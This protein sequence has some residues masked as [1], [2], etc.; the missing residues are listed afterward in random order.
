M[1][2]RKTRSW[3]MPDAGPCGHVSVARLMKRV[4]VHLPFS[5]LAAVLI[6]SSNAMAAFP[7]EQRYFGVTSNAVAVDKSDFIVRAVGDGTVAWLEKTVGGYELWYFD[8]EKNERLASADDDL[9]LLKAIPF[10]RCVA[11]RVRNFEGNA[12]Q[13]EI[14]DPDGPGMLNEPF[15]QDSDPVADGDR[16][17]WNRAIFA[18]E[19]SVTPSSYDLKLYTCGTGAN[20]LASHD[21]TQDEVGFSIGHPIGYFPFQ[22]DDGLVVWLR[23]PLTLPQFQGDVT[24]E[25]WVHDANGT[26]KEWE[27]TY[28]TRCDFYYPTTFG[29]S[30]SAFETLMDWQKRVI[31]AGLDGN[32]IALATTD[33][34]NYRRGVF[35]HRLGSDRDIVFYPGSGV[36]EHILVRDGYVTWLHYGVDNNIENIF[37]YDTASGETL[38]LP[39]DEPLVENLSIDG[40]YVMEKGIVLYK[41]GSDLYLYDLASGKRQFVTSNRAFYTVRFRNGRVALWEME[42]NDL[43]IK[44]FDGATQPRE[45]ARF[46]YSEADLANGLSPSVRQIWLDP[47][48]RVWWV[49]KSFFPYKFDPDPMGSSCEGNAEEWDLFT[50]DP[51]EKQVRQITP[52]SEF[53]EAADFDVFSGTVVWVGLHGLPAECQWMGSGNKPYQ[54]FLGGKAVPYIAGDVRFK[55]GAGV[56]RMLPDLEMILHWG[57]NNAITN[58]KTIYTNANGRFEVVL[59]FSGNAQ[60]RA[61]FTIRLKDKPGVIEVHH[62]NPPTLVSFD[63]AEFTFA[64]PHKV[65]MNIN[66]T[67]TSAFQNASTGAANQARLDDLAQVYYSSHQAANFLSTMYA[68][69]RPLYTSMGVEPPPP[70]SFDSSLPEE[71]RAFSSASGTFHT[72]GAPEFINISIADSGLKNSNWPDNREWHEFAH[73]IMAD[74]LLGGDNQ[75]PSPRL[76]PSLN[77]DVDDNRD[78][79]FNDVYPAWNPATNSV[80]NYREGPVQAANGLDKNHL[81]YANSTTTDSLIEGF[82]E[83]VSLV[84]ADNMTTDPNPHVY[85]F[86]GTS[87]NLESLYFA[88][89]S[90]EDAVAALLWDLYD[91]QVD[92]YTLWG[93]KLEDRVDLTF[94]DLFNRLNDPDVRDMKDVYDALSDL[95]QDSDG[96]GIGDVDEIFLMHGFFADTAPSNMKYDDGEEIGRAAHDRLFTPQRLINFTTDNFLIVDSNSNGVPDANDSNPRLER[97]RVPGQPDRR[98]REISENSVIQVK[99]IDSDT[100]QAV[101][102]VRL[103][104]QVIYDEPYGDFNYTYELRMDGDGNM[105]IIMPQLPS[106]AIIV[107]KADGYEDSTSFT[108]T[109]E[110]YWNAMENGKDFVG[111]N[112]FVLKPVPSYSLEVSLAGDGFGSIMSQPEG[113]DCGNDCSKKFPTDSSVTLNAEAERGSVFNGWGDDCA[114][115][116]TDPSCPLVMSGDMACSAS[117]V[118][119]PNQTPV[120]DSFQVDVS[121]GKA[122]L[123]VTFQCVAHDPDG[124]IFEYRWDLDGDGSVDKTSSD[125]SLSHAYTTPATYAAT[126][127]VVDDSGATSTSSE[128]TITV[129]GVLQPGDDSAAGGNNKQNGAGNGNNGACFI[130]TAAYGS[131]L[132]PQVA[133]LRAF[134]DEY[135]LTNAPGRAFVR[136]YYRYSPPVAEVIAEY[137]ALKSGVRAL[138]APL[139]WAIA[140]PRGALVVIIVLVSGLTIAFWIRRETARP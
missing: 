57:V 30:T 100:K 135:L 136:F 95:N 26:R 13:W 73:H 27:C 103:H 137:P 48:G 45:I 83:F 40:S 93:K 127:T 82:A 63:T 49:V 84:I 67:N 89:R 120:I 59:P 85:S 54:I 68:L 80:V 64:P 72:T 4:L 60:G 117:F 5:I 105:P 22:I 138:L 23:Y 43:V 44:L 9:R 14:Y 140:H 90:E 133:L 8:G 91:S 134:R 102:G 96:D 50:W 65:N 129:S 56:V 71:I 11:Y 51:I 118:L 108:L 41:D 16:L 47:D 74:S 101:Q 19:Q 39:H 25:I 111:Q 130:A 53:N 94:T 24:A 116:G 109:A 3:G 52:G 124:S 139:V 112:D 58:T 121:E 113:I 1:Y 123:A 92:S 10:G 97:I 2:F 17:V 132:E 20:I 99:F 79:I 114:V 61:K 125:G 12:Y 31:Q 46:Q 128:L 78:G 38:T 29:S 76:T 75:Q 36:Y 66:V 21:A 77:V 107:A 115:C 62:G 87:I 55:D 15:I 106:S 81:G 28:P 7:E 42:G 104:V 69:E 18:S 110:D 126:C 119:S 131:Y 86:S 122:P 33:M 34:N 32:V 37:V 70:L 98:N 35:I 6:V 88:W